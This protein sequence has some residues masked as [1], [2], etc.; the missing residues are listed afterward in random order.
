MAASGSTERR[1][2]AGHAC[3]V[4][5]VAV[6]HVVALAQSSAR[7]WTA[8]AANRGETLDMRP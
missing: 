8:G 7:H 4:S 1:E 6:S 5:I 3:S 2:I